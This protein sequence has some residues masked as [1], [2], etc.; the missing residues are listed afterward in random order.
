MISGKFFK[1]SK[2]IPFPYKSNSL[3]QK[4]IKDEFCPVFTIKK[5]G[6]LYDNML[7]FKTTSRKVGRLNFKGALIIIDEV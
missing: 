3:P 2:R 1:L 6:L 4:G 5:C 7:F